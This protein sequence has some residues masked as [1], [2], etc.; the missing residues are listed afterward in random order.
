[1]RYL[2]YFVQRWKLKSKLWT[3][4]LMKKL[5]MPRRWFTLK[6]PFDWYHLVACSSFLHVFFVRRKQLEWNDNKKQ[7]KR[8]NSNPI[9][10]RKI[11]SCGLYRKLL[12]KNS[13]AIFVC[14]NFSFFL[15]SKIHIDFV[16]EYLHFLVN[17][18]FSEMVL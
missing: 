18:Q 13:L 12:K 9:G 11:T 14:H 5:V 4:P 8:K 7:A 16:A 10:D 6:T 2:R 1:V 15:Y 17:H 3:V